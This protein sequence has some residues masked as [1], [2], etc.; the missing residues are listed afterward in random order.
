M[1]KA[2]EETKPEKKD[3]FGSSKWLQKTGWKDLRD[4][5]EHN[6]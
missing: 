3:M 1:V 4:H 5:R 6:L 2:K